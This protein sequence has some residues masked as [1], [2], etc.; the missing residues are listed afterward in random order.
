MEQKRKDGGS[1]SK[2]DARLDAQWQ[3]ERANYSWYKWQPT[4]VE[5]VLDYRATFVP[6][7]LESCG[8][9]V[10]PTDRFNQTLNFSDWR[11]KTVD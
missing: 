9:V 1:Y 8:C 10:L 3:T 11:F 5:Q 7:V 2:S 6:G 4:C